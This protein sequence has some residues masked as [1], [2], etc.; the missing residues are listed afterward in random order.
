[1]SR[2]CRRPRA[3]FSRT[4]AWCST[5][6]PSAT[7]GARPRSSA[8]PPRGTPSA[9]APRPR[10]ARPPGRAAPRPAAAPPA[11]RRRPGFG[12]VRIGGVE[13]PVA[14]GRHASADHHD[15]RV[16]GRDQVGDADAEPVAD[17]G[18]RLA[19]DQVAVGGGGRDHRARQPRGVATAE[20]LQQGRLEADPRPR[21]AD[22]GVAGGVLLPA[23]LAAARARLA[24]G[25][26][27]HVPELAGHPVVAAS[28]RPSSTTA[29]P[30]PVPSVT[31]SATGCR[32]RAVRRLGQGR[33]VG[34]VVERYRD[35]EALGEARPHRLAA[36]RQVRREHDPL[37]CRVH[38]PRGRQPEPGEPIAVRDGEGGLDDGVLDQLW[39]RV[40]RGGAAEDEYGGPGRRRRPLRRAPWCPLR[41]RRPRPADG[42]RRAHPPAPGR[43]RRRR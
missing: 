1:M 35:A 42:S 22:Q 25:H 14:G 9:R 13:Q 37:P 21:Q 5:T 24:A 7:G 6:W 16:E 39:R 20:L 17:G 33:A 18:E 27:L 36:P 11:G 19:C 34:V 10:P 15:V 2:N 30:M 4:I 3:R 26:D 12:R 32:A 41:R 23:A 31:I 43:G 40:P 29:P 38:E 8:T 28:T